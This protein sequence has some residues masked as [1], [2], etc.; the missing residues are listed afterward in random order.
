M[1]LLPIGL[2]SFILPLAA[3]FFKRTWRSVL[4]LLVGAIDVTVSAFRESQRRS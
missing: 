3:L 4:V 1:N 2:M